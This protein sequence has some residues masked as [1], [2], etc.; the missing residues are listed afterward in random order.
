V[1]VLAALLLLLLLLILASEEEPKEESFAAEEEIPDRVL[2]WRTILRISC[3]LVRTHYH[4]LPFQILPLALI[5]L[6]DL[7]ELVSSFEVCDTP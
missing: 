2:R 6:F 3:P 1:C 5:I 4:W 7:L